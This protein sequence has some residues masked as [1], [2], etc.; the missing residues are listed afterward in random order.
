MARRVRAGR[1][2]FVG[3]AQHIHH[4]LLRRGWGHGQVLACLVGLSALFGAI[5]YAGW[6]RGWPEAALFWPFFFGFFAYHFAMTRAWE[7]LDREAAAGM[8]GQGA[9]P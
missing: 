2:P 9:A 5:G 7:R 6:R 1:S 8:P 3:D 4:Y